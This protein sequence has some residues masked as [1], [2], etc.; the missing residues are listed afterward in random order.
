MEVIQ[1]EIQNISYVVD[2][3]LTTF[4]T[5]SEQIY[6]NNE[7][8]VHQFIT[9]V[10]TKYARFFTFNEIDPLIINNNNNYYRVLLFWI[11]PY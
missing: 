7:L 8:R 6:Y 1:Q 3:E 4:H 11:A 2:E 9:S 5:T 10:K